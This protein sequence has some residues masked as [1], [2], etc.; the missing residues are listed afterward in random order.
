M[1]KLYIILTLSLTAALSLTG[2]SKTPNP[3]NEAN[4][5]VADETPSSEV[6][7]DNQEQPVQSE[8]GPIFENEEMNFKVELPLVLKDKMTEEITTQEINEE[9]ITTA[10]IY[11]T[12]EADKV[13]VISFDEM[14]EGLWKQMQEEGGPVGMELGKS[15]NGR[16]IIMNSLQAN[17]FEEGSKDYEAM[18]QF[19]VQLKSV[20]E[21]FEFLK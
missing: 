12:G 19:P 11:Y 21:S 3:S 13:N 9:I 17:P 6:A 1:K 20:V 2:C 8:G 10:T 16:V 18:N 7:E 15:E 5:V 14:S 4:I